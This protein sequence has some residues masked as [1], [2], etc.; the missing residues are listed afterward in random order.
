MRYL[1]YAVI[2]FIYLYFYYRLVKPMRAKLKAIALTIVFVF[3]I[4]PD[5]VVIGHT[6]TFS[7]KSMVM[8]LAGI[9]AIDAWMEYH[10]KYRN[11]HEK[12]KGCELNNAAEKETDC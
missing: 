12:K 9:E 8:F 10:E 5:P 11:S 3:A 7:S 2:A 6:I 1:I 4:I